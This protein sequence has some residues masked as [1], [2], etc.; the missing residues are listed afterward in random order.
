MLLWYCS[1]GLTFKQFSLRHAFSWDIL[2]PA[3]FSVWH[4]LA[5]SETHTHKHTYEYAVW[6]TVVNQNKSIYKIYM[7]QICGQHMCM[8]VL[9]SFWKKCYTLLAIPDGKWISPCAVAARKLSHL[10]SRFSSALEEILLL[11]PRRCWGEKN[12]WR[13]LESS[14][15]LNST[16]S[17]YRSMTPTVNSASFGG[18]LCLSL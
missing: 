18:F 1:P 17:N 3:F 7:T 12:D 4:F 10:I 11:A 14:G 2:N 6:L 13:L 16:I 15:H 5:T 9:W 8:V